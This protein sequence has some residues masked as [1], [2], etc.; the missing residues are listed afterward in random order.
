MNQINFA[1]LDIEKNEALTKKFD[2][3]SIPTLI[4]FKEGKEVDRLVGQSDADD[5]TSKNLLFKSR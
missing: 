4:L 1:I 3:T 2:V 5:V